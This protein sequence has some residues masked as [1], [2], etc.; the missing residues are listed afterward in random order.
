[1]SA[2]HDEQR[3]RFAFRRLTH[4]LGTREPQWREEPMFPP[5][6]IAR[7]VVFLPVVWVSSDIWL[8]L[9]QRGAV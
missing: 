1:M 2:E 8:L 4:L 5:G 7:D 6:T 9:K 3:V